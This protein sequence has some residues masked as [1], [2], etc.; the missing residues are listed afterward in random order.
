MK[1]KEEKRLR[2]LYATALKERD[3][4]RDED[5]G[6]MFFIGALIFV[7][8]LILLCIGWIVMSCAH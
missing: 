3:E 6:N 1:S 7:I 8:G 5:T 4:A 2:T